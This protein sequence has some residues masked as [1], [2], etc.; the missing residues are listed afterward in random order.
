MD[1]VERMEKILKALGV[2]ELSRPMAF[3]K[4][5][6]H[7]YRAN[8]KRTPTEDPLAVVI[9]DVDGNIESAYRCVE[10]FRVKVEHMERFLAWLL[11]RKRKGIY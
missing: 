6:P 10:G 9:L 2:A 11:T 3:A 4:N 8:L 1:K 7:W 5:P